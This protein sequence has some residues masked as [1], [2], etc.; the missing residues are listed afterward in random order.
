M[1]DKW[2]LIHDLHHELAV[3]RAA[4]IETEDRILSEIYSASL[5]ACETC[6]GGRQNESTTSEADKRTVDHDSVTDSDDL[7][8]GDNGQ[9]IS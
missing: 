7:H 8:T 4:W 3:K 6:E 5:D 9:D 1:K 2:R